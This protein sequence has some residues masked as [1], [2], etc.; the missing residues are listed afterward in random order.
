MK[1]VLITGGAGTLGRCVAE[2][3]LKRNYR[4]RIFDLQSFNCNVAP[5][6]SNFEVVRG[7]ICDPDA[8][9]RATGDV[10]WI[11]HLAAILPPLSENDPNL[12]KTVNIHGTRQLLKVIRKGVP[13]V[14]ASSVAVYGIPQRKIVDIDHPTKPVD[15][16]GETKLQNEREIGASGRISTVL[17]ISGISVP[18]LLE[19]PRPWFFARKQRLQFVH[20][21]DAATAVA[22]CVD[23]KNAVG[24][25]FQIAGDDSWRM[26]GEEYSKAICNAFDMPPES[27]SYLKEPSWPGWYDTRLSQAVFDYQHQCFEKFIEQLRDLYQGAVDEPV[28]DL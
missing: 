13:L 6:G 1:K 18:A 9:S 20:L 16:Y 12:A 26:L 25:I 11:I 19:I 15:Y 14:F 2:A 10:D 17:R 28:D 5:G 4:V 7:D 24:H 27:A 21:A 23:N 8:L 3:L 22:N